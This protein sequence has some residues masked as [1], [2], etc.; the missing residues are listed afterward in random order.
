MATPATSIWKYTTRI[1]FSTAL[2][3]PET[4]RKLLEQCKAA[5]FNAVRVWGG[6]YYPEDWFYDLCDELGLMVW[7]DGKNLLIM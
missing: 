1:T 4:T 6:G 7:Q 3:T 2:I 5:N